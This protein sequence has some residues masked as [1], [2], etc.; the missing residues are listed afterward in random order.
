MNRDFVEVQV[1]DFM[2]ITVEALPHQEIETVLSTI[3]GGGA[4][5]VAFKQ[6]MLKIAG[7]T[8]NK[9]TSFAKDPESAAE[10]FNKVRLALAKT[11][12]PDDIRIALQA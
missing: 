9:L 11:D 8:G 7:W 1:D 5:G 4:K 6:E 2:K 3:G 12:N 10:A